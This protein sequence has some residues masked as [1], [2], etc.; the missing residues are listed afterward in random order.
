[1]NLF[2]IGKEKFQSHNYKVIYSIQPYASIGYI[3]F[4]YIIKKNI[5]I[6]I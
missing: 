3:I 6:K 2:D 1:M 4:K 5:N